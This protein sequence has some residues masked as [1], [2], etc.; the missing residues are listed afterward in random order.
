VKKLQ[1]RGILDAL[2]GKWLGERNLLEETIDQVVIDSREVKLHG[3][4]IAI[5]GQRFDGH[6]FVEQAF[7]LGA[8]V[9]CTS[10]EMVIPAG[11]GL[12]LV[13]DTKIALGRIAGYYRQQFSLPV[14]GI[15]GSV[16][17]T[18][19]RE[20]LASILK[21][22]Y[23]VHQTDKN[24]N[25]DIGVPLT[26][27]KLEEIHEVA[28]IE[29]GMDKFGEID[30]SANMIQPTYGVI[31]NIGVAHIEFLGSREGIFKAKSEMLPH[32]RLG[33]RL[34][35]NG[36]DPFLSQLK[37]TRRLPIQTYGRNAGNDCTVLSH[38]VMETGQQMTAVTK[39]ATYEVSVPY[40]GEAL[41]LNSLVG[42][43]IGEA[44]GL[45]KEEILTGIEAYKPAKMRLELM[46]IGPMRL[47]DDCYNASV[48][49]M[50]SGLKTLT[51]I[52]RKEE[53]T[54][55]IL[56]SMFE[57][58]SYS[59]EGHLEV[60]H[61]VAKYQPDQ[62]IVVGEEGRFIQEGALEAG[63]ESKRCFYYQEQEALL[64]V[65]D[66]HIQAKDLVLLKASRGMALEK[67]REQIKRKFEA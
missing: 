9:V 34:L 15:T 64:Q 25:N 59:K 10:R 17:K 55:A 26:L 52:R 46:Q 1:I 31:T 2:Q 8:R 24:D 30:Y 57:M 47:I 18:S 54:V 48:T 45:S 5:I 56:G 38:K 62:L 50:E 11:K 33:G 7:D 39:M 36:D 6:E 65:L 41:L 37:G 60:G 42:I 67:S 27:L 44:L 51:A 23:Q 58:G 61:L 12:I 49:S 43:L 3:L 29:L 20:M 14:I 22:K 53:R 35:V 40:F 16:G 4:Y 63:Y 21:K 66:E 28:I 32:I 13:K 19:T